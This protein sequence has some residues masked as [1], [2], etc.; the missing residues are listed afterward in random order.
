M[1]S[2]ELVR[3]PR[4]DDFG[5]YPISVDWGLNFEEPLVHVDWGIIRELD[6]FWKHQYWSTFIKL[7]IADMWWFREV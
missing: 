5:K 3:N 6:L 4:L 7:T 1:E 2:Q